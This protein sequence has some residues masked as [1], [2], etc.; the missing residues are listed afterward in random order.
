V[1]TVSLDTV[2]RTLWALVD[3]GLVSTL[4]PRRQSA[5]FDA[6]PRGHHHFVCVRCGLVRDFESVAL[7]ALRI[8]SAAKRF[9]SVTGTRIEVQGVCARCGREKSKGAVSRPPRKPRGK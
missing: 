5:R 8:P 9:G 2:Y 7:D 3:L 4:G 1:P 6:N